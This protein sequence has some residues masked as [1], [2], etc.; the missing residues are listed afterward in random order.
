[1]N[2]TGSFFYF[3]TA[4]A[5]MGTERS[6]DSIIL[7]PQTL[8]RYAKIL[9]TLPN[10]YFEW[11]IALLEVSTFFLVSVLLY[12]AWKKKI[13]TSYLIFSILAFLLPASSGTF[14]GLPR[15]SLVIFPIFI[16]L[17]LLKNRTIQILYVLIS[18]ILLFLLLMFF[19]KGY[20]IA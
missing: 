10:S 1:M 20:F 5:N 19:S 2:K 18:S 17:A 6:A 9:S 11:W 16:A 12:I 4:H 13:R 14:T 15:Y 7:I 8:F 3:L